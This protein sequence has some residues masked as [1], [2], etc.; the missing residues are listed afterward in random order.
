MN[1]HT[2][3]MLNVDIINTDKLNLSNSFNNKSKMF[4]FVNLSSYGK[5]SLPLFVNWSLRA[6]IDCDIIQPIIV[7][8]LE[9]LK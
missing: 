4:L 9:L 5:V 2:Y 1:I 3:L 7:T 6:R 8:I